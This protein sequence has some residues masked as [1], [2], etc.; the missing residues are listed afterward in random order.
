M[1]SFHFKLRRPDVLE[2]AEFAARELSGLTAIGFQWAEETGKRRLQ[3]G[4]LAES[5]NEAPGNSRLADPHDLSSTCAPS[6]L[7]ILP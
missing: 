7:K 6:F 2:I 1:V 4:R 5:L 3:A